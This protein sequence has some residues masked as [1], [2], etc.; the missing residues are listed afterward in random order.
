[1][2]RS[3][4]TFPKNGAPVLD[5][6]KATRAALANMQKGKKNEPA[7]VCLSSSD[8][9]CLSSS[10]EDEVSSDSN[11]S[12]Q[13]DKFKFLKRKVCVKKNKPDASVDDNGLKE[14]LC[15]S[16]SDEDLVGSSDNAG[17]AQ[18]TYTG[19]KNPDFKE[20]A[21]EHVSAKHTYLSDSVQPKKRRKIP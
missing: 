6:Y 1:M 14:E 5:P 16:S 9:V 2:A 20:N 3:K 10:D 21:G 7:E 15:F 19:P 8:E 18:R 4:E 17:H 13:N 12:M 11:K